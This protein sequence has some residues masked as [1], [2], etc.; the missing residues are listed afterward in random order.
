MSDLEN[1]LHQL[2]EQVLRQELAHFSVELQRN[3]SDVNS[4]P[5]IERMV[6]II[7]ETVLEAVRLGIALGRGEEPALVASSAP[8]KA[9]AKQVQAPAAVEQWSQTAPTSEAPVEPVDASNIQASVIFNGTV[10][11]VASPFERF[12]EVQR[13]QRLLE[14][15]PRI[16]SVKPKRFAGGRLI[17]IIETEFAD[18]QSL[19]D[20]L[21]TE[22]ALFRPTI[23]S[24][25]RDLIELILKPMVSAE[26]PA[27]NQASS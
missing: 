12:V 16:S 26:E 13:F 20:T 5:I 11:L 14:R 19:A 23:R 15:I 2:V 25:Q 7:H 22:L 1:D 8:A 9:D 18:T 21:L 3:A 27:Q 4:M 17:L 6:P 24:A 10:T